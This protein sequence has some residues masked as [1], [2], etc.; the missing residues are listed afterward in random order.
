M[1]DDVV[2]LHPAVFRTLAREEHTRAFIRCHGSRRQSVQS[3]RLRRV[4]ESSRACSGGEQ[5]ILLMLAAL[6]WRVT[7]CPPAAQGRCFQEVRWRSPAA[8]RARRGARERVRASVRRRVASLRGHLDAPF[9]RNAYSLVG[10]TLATSGFGVIFWIVAAHLFTKEEVG[11]DTALISTML[12]LSS[13][14]QLNLTNGFNRFVPVAGVPHPPVRPHRLPRDD[15]DRVRRVDRVRARHQ[16]VGAAALAAPRP[17]DLRG[18]VRAR[19]RRVDGVRAPGRSVDGPRRSALGADRERHLR[20]RQDRAALLR[21]RVAARARRLR[22]LDA[23][24]HRRRHRGQRADLQ[25]DGP[26]RAPTSRWRRS[27]RRPCATTSAST[28]SRR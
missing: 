12:F 3:P 5:C 10:S 8:R 6:S 26:G 16:P 11:R 22:G 27:T 25:A 14:S 9:V 24:A 28:W 2:P 15:V 13:I 17:L 18:V 4:P 7:C 23:A 21:G 19:H 1:S 20:R